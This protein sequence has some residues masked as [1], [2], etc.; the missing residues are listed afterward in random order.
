MQTIQ[1]LKTEFKPKYGI[2]SKEEIIERVNSEDNFTYSRGFRLT[3]D[4]DIK[5]ILVPRI[6]RLPPAPLA[7]K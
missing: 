7:V 6:K 5:N 2:F 3:E 4:K 1:P